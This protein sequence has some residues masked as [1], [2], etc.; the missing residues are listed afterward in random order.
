MRDPFVF[1]IFSR[2]FFYSRPFFH[3]NI[4]VVFVLWCDVMFTLRAASFFRIHA[5]FITKKGKKKLC[6]SPILP[7]DCLLV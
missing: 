5:S 2:P 7:F 6:V 1:N 3:S 4:V